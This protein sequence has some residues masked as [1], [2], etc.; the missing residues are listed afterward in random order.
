MITR[1]LRV[2]RTKIMCATGACLSLLLAQQTPVLAQESD[3]F[4]LLYHAVIVDQFS[5][6]CPVMSATTIATLAANMGDLRDNVTVAKT[7]NPARYQEL[8]GDHS[9]LK[10][11]ERAL[12]TKVLFG[13]KCDNQSVNESVTALKPFVENTAKSSLIL[14]SALQHF[15]ITG[16]TV[17]PAERREMANLSAELK[18]QADVA[19]TLMDF[20]QQVSGA[21]NLV[22]AAAVLS[23]PTSKDY[24][25]AI[26]QYGADAGA[27]FGREIAKSL[28]ILRARISERNAEENSK[29]RTRRPRDNTYWMGLRDRSNTVTTPW[30]VFSTG[31]AVD[32][33]MSCHLF[34]NK[35]GRLG[36]LLSNYN[37]AAPK[38]IYVAMR[39]PLKQ[40]APT[41]YLATDQPTLRLDW[42]ARETNLV[43]P[44]T[45]KVYVASEGLEVTPELV[46]EGL[47]YNTSSRLYFFPPDTL[48]AFKTLSDADFFSMGIIY[49][50]EDGR[51]FDTFGNDLP[52]GFDP[53]ISGLATTAFPVFGYPSAISWAYSPEP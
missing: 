30:L 48:N 16:I 22:Y 33:T 27:T 38:N 1:D 37:G 31:C 29:P 50:H 21:Q 12:R 9:S 6:K 42:K 43:D 5:Q 34:V 4:A 15:T 11:F 46:P 35:E 20:E 41:H 51:L 19:G 25:T 36:L 28:A 24:P 26:A 32:A 47:A 13:A 45:A 8:V 49:R 14:A 3:P 18:A 44:A 10:A 17:S 23:N 40:E 53:D 2:L 7:T 52:E 39:D